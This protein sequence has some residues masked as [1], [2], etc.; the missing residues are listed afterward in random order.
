MVLVAEGDRLLPSHAHLGDVGRSADPGAHPGQ[1]H[2]DEQSAEDAPSG[3]GIRAWMKQLPNLPESLLGAR[4]SVLLLLCA[5]GCKEP[6]DPRGSWLI[7]ALELFAVRLQM[8]ATHLALKPSYVDQND[9]HGEQIRNLNHRKN[10]VFDHDSVDQKQERGSNPEVVRPNAYPR[11][12]MLLDHMADLRR[13]GDDYQ[14]RSE[15]TREL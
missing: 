5:R 4:R 14:Y 3:D 13:V 7:E 2:H 9:T 1:P 15:K 12:T 10:K 8:H 11:G 6:M